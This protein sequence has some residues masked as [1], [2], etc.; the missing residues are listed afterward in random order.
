MKVILHRSD[1]LIL[2]ESYQKKVID[3]KTCQEYLKE[4]WK[5]DNL[6]DME[7]KGK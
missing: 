5:S 7:K 6:E 3:R 1:S 2:D 4:M